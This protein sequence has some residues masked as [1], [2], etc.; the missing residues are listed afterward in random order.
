MRKIFIAALAA[1]AMVSCAKD[2]AI[3]INNG[4]AIGFAATTGRTTRAAT[5]D[6]YNEFNMFRVWGFHKADATAAETALMTN[7][8]VEKNQ[9]GKGEWRYGDSY[10]WP[11]VGTCDFYGIYPTTDDVATSPIT[12]DMANKTVSY[13][14]YT[15]NM[16]DW[17]PTDWVY[18]VNVDEARQ[19]TKVPMN[20]RHAMSQIVFQVK[21][22]N[23]RLKVTIPEG[24]IDLMCASQKG[25]YTLPS[26]DTAIEAN[27]A[28]RVM[29]SWV[30]ADLSEGHGCY[31]WANIKGTVLDGV[32]ECMVADFMAEDG[33]MITVPQTV[34]AYDYR[35]DGD[36]EK[37]LAY[38]RMKVLIEQED[39][40]I[41]PG[42]SASALEE[43]VKGQ[44]Y[45][46]AIPIS[47]TWEEG[48][49]YTYTL[50]FGN[51]AGIVPP[52]TPVP[53]GE[54][55]EPGDPILAPIRFTVTIDDIVDA[56]NKDIYM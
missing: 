3:E 1:V 10:F 12:V 42:Y 31:V 26:E 4:E 47:A 35:E 25:V 27:Y 28:D 36:N 34:A 21:N 19:T 13:D 32:S 55:I 11:T 51:G 5:I 44:P 7:I 18:A 6:S 39:T 8:L 9:D 38:F 2:E 15:G 50:I 23:S 41:W 46:V 52:G 54:E 33:A 40:E 22:T 17:N 16:M 56:G 48:K 14:I 24:T 37:Q 29:G 53:P 20:F 49:K 30:V 45:W 43:V